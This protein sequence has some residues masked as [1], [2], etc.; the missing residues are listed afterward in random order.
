MRSC[1][2][3]DSPWA[4]SRAR[5]LPCK[6]ASDGS[7]NGH[8]CA[9]FLR[10]SRPGRACGSEH[11]RSAE[12]GEGTGANRRA[13]GGRRSHAFRAEFGYFVSN[14]YTVY[15]RRRLGISP[16]AQCKCRDRYAGL[17]VLSGTLPTV[18]ALAGRLRESRTAAER[19]H[20]GKTAM[21]LLTALLDLA[22]AIS[23][24]SR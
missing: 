20:A 12:I 1:P 19:R 22:D 23:R 21:D 11:L 2:A 13:C 18:L 17:F 8:L 24:E 4:F 15:S 7:L 9:R 14:S 5:E 3:V 6:K 10:L 16:Q